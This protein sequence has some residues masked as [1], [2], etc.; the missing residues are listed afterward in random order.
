MAELSRV[1]QPGGVLI[2]A[3]S[4]DDAEFKEFHRDDVRVPVDPADLPERTRNRHGRRDG[5]SGP[6]VM[7]TVMG[8]SESFTSDLATRVANSV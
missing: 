1:L 2:G 3:D 6:G 7:I 4:L 8:T 5:R